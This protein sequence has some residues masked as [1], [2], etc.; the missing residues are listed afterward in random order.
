MRLTRVL[1]DANVLV[2]AQLRDLFL[3]LAEAGLIEVY[4][5]AEIMHELRGAL[6]QA[7]GLDETKVDRLILALDSAFPDASVQ[8]PE[9]PSIP[10]LPD[11]DDR[12]CRRSRISTRMRPTNHIQRS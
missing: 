5:S 4:W 1:L 9:L 8:A 7:R 3:R 11:P 2:D 10:E 12:H 6:T